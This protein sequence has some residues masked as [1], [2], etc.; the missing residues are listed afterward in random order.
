MKVHK[1]S[2]IEDFNSFSKMQWFQKH[3]ESTTLC[4]MQWFQKTTQS[5]KIDKTFTMKC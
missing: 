4:T 2:S 1:R 5:K 3:S